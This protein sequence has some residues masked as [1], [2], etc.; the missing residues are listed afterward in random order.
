MA[1]G[2]KDRWTPA[3]LLA[4]A[5]DRSTRALCHGAGR[6]ARPGAWTRGSCWAPNCTLLTGRRTEPAASWAPRRHDVVG[7]ALRMRARSAS[8]TTKNGH[9]V[10]AY[11]FRMCR[12]RSRVPVRLVWWWW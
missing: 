10:S 4:Q 12:A 3:D 9:M 11:T 1:G 7:P 8:L 2:T 6:R 5:L